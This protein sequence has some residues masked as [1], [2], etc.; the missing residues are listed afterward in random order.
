MNFDLELTGKR[1]LVTGGTR[2]LGAAVVELLA[3]L[4]A[5]VVATARS[6]PQA[7]IKGVHYMEADLAS[8]EG[9]LRAGEATLH[10]LG[11]IDVLINVV[12]GSS[13][14]AGGFAA[15]DDAEWA[16][17]LDLN[18][19]SAVRLDRAL[20]PA[21]IAQGSGV[22]M[23]VT[24]IQR[25]LPLP[26]ATTAYAAAKAALSTYSKALS[27]EVTPKGVRVVR[28]APGWIETDA[29][30]AFVER[31]AAE[32]QTDYEGGRKRV[33]DGLGGIPLGRPAQPGEVADLIAFL[34]SPRAASISGT[35]YTIDGGT[36]P[37]V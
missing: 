4:G 17:A 26:E 19:M 29:A 8:A 20:L 28:V 31:I 1:V 21:M 14:P 3:R 12:G 33:M 23:H 5:R 11:G 15:L 37:T 18:L 9:A 36:V 34:V 35:E 24:S 27:K 25:T 6:L 7:P 30:V 16:R 13:A 2:G 22:I 10:R 32:A